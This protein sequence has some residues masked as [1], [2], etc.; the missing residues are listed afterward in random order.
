MSISGGK[1]SSAVKN[2]YN[3][4]HY[5]RL[6]VFVPKDDGQV[7]RAAARDRGLSLNAFVCACVYREIWRRKER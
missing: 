3:R 1:T 2:R 6:S 7:I 5:D 4:K